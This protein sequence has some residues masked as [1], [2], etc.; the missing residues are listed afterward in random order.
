MPRIVASLYFKDCADLVLIEIDGEKLPGTIQW[1]EG[2]MTDPKPSPDT[3]K[4][5]DTTV[6]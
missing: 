3:L 2:I 5:S 4:K 6:Q 1:V